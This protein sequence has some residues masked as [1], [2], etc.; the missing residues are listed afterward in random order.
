MPNRRQ[1]LAAL[2]TSALTS[3]LWVPS[4]STV[5]GPGASTL[6]GD[7]EDPVIAGLIES[8]LRT[9]E[10]RDLRAEAMRTTNPEWVFMGRTFAGLGLLAAM[11]ARPALAKRVVPAVDRMIDATLA[12]VRDRGQLHFL[13]GYARLAPF[14]NPLRTSLFVDGELLV[15]LAARERLVHDGRYA[16]EQAAL[17]ERVRANLDASP[18]GHGESYPDECWAFCN[19]FAALGLKLDD[20]TAGR[21]HREALARYVRTTRRLVEPQTGML[22]SEYTWDGAAM[23]GPEGSS[24]YLAAALLD[25][26]EPGWGRHQY[27]L[28]R[29]HLLRSFL[30]FGYSREWRGSGTIDIDSGPIVPVFE[31][32]SAASGMALVGAGAFE[33]RD[34]LET[35]LASLWAC[36]FPTWHDGALSF[37]ASNPVGDAVM[38][39]AL[40]Q[41]HLDPGWNA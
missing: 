28:A 33:D 27:Q 22:V 1:F 41:R 30:G 9:L 35:L 29:Q 2:G 21:D 32:G 4:L 31:A 8:Q 37:A 39:F 40:L 12:A 16:V 36:A 25:R 10:G 6:D 11:V 7:P 5:F 17:A 23:D 24:I 19:A 18:I 26:V 38:L 3:A 14:R 20:R 13:M 34:A 15:L